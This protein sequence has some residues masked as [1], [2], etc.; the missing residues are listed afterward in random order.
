MRRAGCAAGVIGLLGG[1]GGCALEEALVDGWFQAITDIIAS[2]ITI[3][4]LGPG[5]A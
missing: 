4:V 1:V 3:A 2:W 5:A